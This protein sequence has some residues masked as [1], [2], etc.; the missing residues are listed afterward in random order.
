MQ[1]PSSVKNKQGTIS[2]LSTLFQRHLAAAQQ[3]REFLDELKGSSSL[4]SL[5]QGLVD[6]HQQ[7]AD[8]LAA[9]I[10]DLP[11]V[12]V[13]PNRMMRSGDDHM[14]PTSELLPETTFAYYRHIYG[15]E[16]RLARHYAQLL[17]NE[18]LPKGIMERIQRQH[19]AILGAANKVH[20][21]IKT[22]EDRTML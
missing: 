18:G 14:P 9:T 20:R 2:T 21:L 22:G 4:N 12:P 3:Y 6:M 15:E 13:K 1:L 5:L 16:S 7:L 8:Q 17:D 10:R 19:K 11:D